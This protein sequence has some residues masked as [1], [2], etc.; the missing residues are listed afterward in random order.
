MTASNRWRKPLIYIAL[1]LCLLSLLLVIW[2]GYDYKTSNTN[3]KIQIN[4]EDKA[5]NLATSSLMDI[6]NELY[7]TSLHGKGIAKDLSYGKLKNDSAIEKCLRNE[8]ESDSNVLSIAVAYSPAY[9]KKYY[10]L[11]F[12]RNGT[13]VEPAPIV[14]NYTDE[15]EESAVWYANAIKRGFGAWN[16]PYF[17]KGTKSYQVVYSVPFY[18]AEF[19]NGKT[20]AGVV[21]VS[22]S[23]VGIRSLVGKLNLG[24]TGY[25]FILSENGLIISHPL[26]KYLFRNIS[27]LVKGDKNFEYITKNM[28]KN[29]SE[30]N[31]VTGKSLWVFNETINSTN[32]T[33]GVVLPVEETIQDKEIKQNR[34]VIHVV[35]ATFAFLFFMCLL[36]VSLYRYEDKSLWLLAFI[37]S[38]LC[39]AGTGIIWH[40]TLNDSPHNGMNGDFIVSDMTDVETVLQNSTSLN[41]H[42][43][44]TGIFLQSLEFTSAYNV[45]AS[46]YIWQNI[47]ETDY[48]NETPSFSFP[49]SQDTTIEKAYEDENRS[50]IGWHFTTTLRQQFNYSRYPFDRE[51]IW[52]RI[53]N[54]DS[55]KNVLLPDFDSYDSLNPK[56]YPG[57]ERSLVL[58]GW[59]PQRTYFSYRKNSYNTNFGKG[60]FKHFNVPELYFNVDIKRDFKSPFT[61][62]ILPVLVVAILLFAVLMITTKDEKKEQCGF[63]SSDVLGYCSALFFV[64]IL[65]HASLRDK[66]PV[67]DIIYLEYFYFIMYLAILAVSLNSIAFASSINFP[68]I[69]AK[70]NLYVKVLYW[71]IVMG[72][73]L[74]IT[75]MN[76]Y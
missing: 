51:D 69:D 3:E 46:G 24:N 28:S 68:L 16:Q 2:V 11:H 63:S 18:L 42:R 23:L 59:E 50:V 45:V 19:E 60:D 43:I 30:I 53:W 29:G 26:Q 38:F 57:F 44:P 7:N 76:F 70:D 48:D 1:L 4:A 65:A 33:M 58:E 9:Y 21:G 20:A 31:T 56:M 64:L 67:D 74:L 66:I 73:L 27:E 14:Y 6:S 41:A 47:S 62:Y 54:N 12:K 71:P 35:L 22:S 39:I 49:E 52:V 32:W 10:S 34:S 72:I 5:H 25:G 36:F 13:A 40:L 37:F 61:S 17:G 55:S 75:L 15:N 8:I